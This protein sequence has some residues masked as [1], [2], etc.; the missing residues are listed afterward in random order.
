MPSASGSQPGRAAR[1]PACDREEAAGR[2]ELAPAASVHLRPQVEPSG[3]Q[4]N[5]LR[6]VLAAVVEWTMRRSLIARRSS[7]TSPS[8]VRQPTAAPARRA[9]ARAR[10]GASPR[11]ARPRPSSSRR[12]G[13]EDRDPPGG[14]ERPEYEP[15][16]LVAGED[17]RRQLAPR[18]AGSRRPLR[19][20][21][22]RRSL[23]SATSR[24]TQGFETSSS[25]IC[26][27]VAKRRARSSCTKRKSRSAPHPTSSCTADRMSSG[28]TRRRSSRRRDAGATN[29]RELGRAPSIAESRSGTRV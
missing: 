12:D 3:A 29:T 6:A 8:A 5:G 16:Q 15:R 1:A 14:D 9:A 26:S 23:R 28:S 7:A 19:P 17:Q 2:S 13:G 22:E 20:G 4:R 10:R 27:P 18:S 21:S 25:A 24:Q 11:A